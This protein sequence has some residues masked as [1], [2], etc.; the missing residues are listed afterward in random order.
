MR[1]SR[2]PTRAASVDL[3]ATLLAPSDLR[4]HASRMRTF[5]SRRTAHETSD[6]GFVDLRKPVEVTSHGG[7]PKAHSQFRSGS[8]EHLAQMRR[9]HR[10]PVASRTRSR[11]H[12]RA[13]R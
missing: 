8:V 10:G 3:H 12:S 2:K 1:V 7:A 11:T 5:G 4:D 13:R 6:Y 9:L